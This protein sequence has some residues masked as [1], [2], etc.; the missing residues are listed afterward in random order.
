MQFSPKA[1]LALVLF[2]LTLVWG[3]CSLSSPQ[4]SSIPWNHPADWEGQ[5]P[6]MNANGSGAR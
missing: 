2:A 5:M 1:V 3:G 6:G 4:N